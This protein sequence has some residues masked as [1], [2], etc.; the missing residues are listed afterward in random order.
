MPSMVLKQDET[1]ETNFR[2][3]YVREDSDM[4]KMSSVQQSIQEDGPSV[5][6]P[7]TSFEAKLMTNEEKPEEKTFTVS[8][9]KVTIEKKNIESR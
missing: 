7:N 4:K 3:K 2:K 8:D 1:D 5:N 6:V 9:S